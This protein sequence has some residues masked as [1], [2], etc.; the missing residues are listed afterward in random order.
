MVIVRSVAA[1]LGAVLARGR[2]TGRPLRRV[3][4]RDESMKNTSRKNIVSIIGMISILVRLSSRRRLNSTMFWL[5]DHRYRAGMMVLSMLGAL[6][7]MQL[8]QHI[9]ELGRGLLRL[10]SDGGQAR[11]EIVVGDEADDRDGQARRRC[12]QRLADTGQDRVAVAPVLLHGDG[13][14]GADHADDGP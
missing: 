12:I 1:C 5:L 11:G 13:V 6:L 14:E 10:R 7:M 4:A 3:S 8:G 2:F 9:D